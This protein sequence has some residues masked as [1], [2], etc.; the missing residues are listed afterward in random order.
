[1]NFYLEIDPIYQINDNISL[2]TL[3]VS[4]NFIFKKY[5][6]IVSI[7]KEKIDSL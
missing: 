1:M 7:E 4:K 3:D 5:Y 2:K 6:D